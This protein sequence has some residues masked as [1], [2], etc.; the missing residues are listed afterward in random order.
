[1]FS[2]TQKT[3]PH[4]VFNLQATNLVHCEKETGVNTGKYTA[5]L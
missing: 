5:K 2:D 3:T 4:T 1:M